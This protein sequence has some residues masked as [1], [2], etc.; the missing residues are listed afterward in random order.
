MSYS[1]LISIIHPFTHNLSLVFYKYEGYRY[2]VS[3]NCSDHGSGDRDVASCV[4][5]PEFDSRYWLRFFSYR[6]YCVR[7]LGR[8]NG[9]CREIRHRAW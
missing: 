6:P 7:G 9:Y 4:R 5:G 8:H 2:L 3:N 1:Q